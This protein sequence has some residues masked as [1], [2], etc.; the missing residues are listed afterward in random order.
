MRVNQKY[1]QSFGDALIPLL[2]YFFWNWN[3]YFIVLFY[4]LDLIASEVFMYFKS[5]KIL[6]VQGGKWQ[7]N[8]VYPFLSLIFMATAVLLVH[9]SVKLIEH[10]I[11]FS[12]EIV[13]FWS[14][15]D[16][17]I[18]QG[19]L[20]V[21]LLFMV[22]FQRFKLEFIAQK[23]HEKVSMSRLWNVHFK[24][25]IILLALIGMVYGITFFWVFPEIV[26]LIGLILCTTAYRIFKNELLQF[27]S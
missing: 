18:E 7:E 5:K 23:Q 24:E 27:L 25:N 22:G 26:Y 4:L 16:L 11:S 14:Y 9:L 17:G 10:G 13:A 12:K 2:G 8:V 20:L 19:Y 21:P 15:K 6:Q 1:V 3:L